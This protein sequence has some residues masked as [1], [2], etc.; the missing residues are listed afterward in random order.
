M[1][2]LTEKLVAVLCLA[3]LGGS[4]Q[5]PTRLTGTVL[6]AAGLPV[7]GA[8]VT[9][10]DAEGD[11]ESIVTDVDGRFVFVGFHPAKYRVKAVKPGYLTSAYG[12]RRPLGQGVSLDFSRVPV[13]ENLVMMLARGG[14]V[15]GSVVDVQGTPAPAVEI[16]L[17]RL[18]TD[19][20][21]FTVHEQTRTITDSFGRYRSSGLTPG[22]YWV[23]AVP[24]A[25][26]AVHA[27]EVNVDHILT[28]LNRGVRRNFDRSSVPAESP[29]SV[30]LV[31]VFYPGVT[32][33]KNA[34][35]VEVVAGSEINAIDIALQRVE[36]NVVRGAARGDRGQ[37]LT[38]VQV[39]LLRV[40]VPGA[41][42]RL[43]ETRTIGANHDGR[44]EFRS[45][46]SGLYE[47]SATATHTTSG[48]TREALSATLPVEVRNG[49]ALETNLSLAPGVEVHGHVVPSQ[50]EGTVPLGGWTTLLTPIRRAATR[51]DGTPIYHAKSDE[52]GSF[53][54]GPMPPGA[55]R[56][57]I[58]SQTNF[59]V[60]QA[61]FNG[62]DVLDAPLIVAPGSRAKLE[63]STSGEGTIVSGRVI[64]PAHL[65][66]L[67]FHVVVYP[68]DQ[69]KWVHPRRRAAVRVATDGE[70]RVQGLPEGDYLLAVVA[71]L[72]ETELS[73]RRFMQGLVDASVP[74]S[75]QLGKPVI[76][77][78]RI[79]IE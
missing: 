40:D 52:T 13:L 44:F 38:E 35:L 25:G 42:G 34:G 27:P 5:L 72:D 16:S 65:E 1:T 37:E 71:D 11:S 8:F 74:I 62:A 76:Q 28:Q 23:V 24:A 61:A 21:G 60:M 14:V 31:P 77:D 73:S 30:I 32:V 9:L 17:L 20:M 26:S 43:S 7:A 50:R 58:V 66:P 57:S 3:G 41:T 59:A 2:V 19:G 36:G 15:S 47:L 4:L 6:N 68:K 64:V 75:L 55:Y 69:E 79:R 45:V 18:V 49:S 56:V 63:L 70:F 48:G 29:S 12:A 39:S 51:V 10:V 54:L 22:D 53:V 67:E 46:P 78:L 33:A